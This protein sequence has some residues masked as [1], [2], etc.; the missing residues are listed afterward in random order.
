[1]IPRSVRARRPAGSGQSGSRRARNRPRTLVPLARPPR[2]CPRREVRLPESLS[3]RLTWCPRPVL[4]TSRTREQGSSR[5][6]GPDNPYELPREVIELN[7]R[8]RAT[9]SNPTVQTNAPAAAVDCLVAGAYRL[10]GRWASM[11]EARSAQ[12]VEHDQRRVRNNLGHTHRARR[13]Q[14]AKQRHAVTIEALHPRSQVGLRLARQDRLDEVRAGLGGERQW[15]V[16]TRRSS[17][18]VDH[19]T[20][21]SALP[22]ALPAP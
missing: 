5:Q 10:P 6:C 15:A 13:R 2:H 21:P 4:A 18:T 20:A 17:P 8:R 16:E 11:N 3:S 12:S 22:H 7:P 14:A 1:M 9:Q 19:G